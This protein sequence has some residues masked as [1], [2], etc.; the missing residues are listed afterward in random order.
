MAF[1]KEWLIFTKG[2]EDLQG[3][4]QSKEELW[5]NDTSHDPNWTK[6]APNDQW[7]MGFNKY[8]SKSI[9]ISPLAG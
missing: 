2:A 3:C 9:F 5:A 4:G 7:I 6:I 1:Y 8:Y